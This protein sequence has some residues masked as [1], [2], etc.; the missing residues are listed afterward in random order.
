MS[1]AVGKAAFLCLMGCVASIAFQKRAA[2]APAPTFYENILPILRDHCQSC[3]RAG[4][5]APMSLVTYDETRPWAQKMA[6]AV[7][8]KMM[9]PWFADPR[10]G[11][12][13]NDPSLTDQQIAAISRWAEAG[14]PAGEL[15]DAPTPRKWTEGWTISQPDLVIK[16]P[17]AVR[18]PAQGEVEYTYEIVRTRFNRRSVG[19]DV[20][21]AA[22]ERGTCASRCGLYSTTR[23]DVAETCPGGRAVYGID[24]E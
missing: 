23:F 20:G 14:A 13:A 8:M 22:V 15:R 17:T 3:H 10:F 16:M 1:G 5:A 19:A 6:T 11:H 4:E 2:I 9:P 12:F 21:V 7:E 24:L 18:I